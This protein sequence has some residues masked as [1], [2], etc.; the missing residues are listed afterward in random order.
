MFNLHSNT[1]QSFNKSNVL[2]DCQISTFSNKSFMF[3]NLYSDIDVT[4]DYIWILITFTCK[5]IIVLVRATSFHS[6]LELSLNFFNFLTFAIFASVLLFHCL[7]HSFTICAF[8]LSLGI[9]SW[10]KLY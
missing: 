9:H 7:S 3:F 6:Y 4:C 5:Y 10:T 8:L 1:T 2:N